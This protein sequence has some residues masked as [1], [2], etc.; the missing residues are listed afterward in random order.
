MIFVLE[1]ELKKIVENPQIMATV[2]LKNKTMVPDLEN[3]DKPLVFITATNKFLFFY[4][5]GTNKNTSTLA[6]PITSIINVQYT[7]F[8]I[9]KT[10]NSE[11]K[12]KSR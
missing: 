1:V 12:G 10:V 4:Q 8:A 11:S 7:D 2:Q 3:S 9:G 5:Y 6:I